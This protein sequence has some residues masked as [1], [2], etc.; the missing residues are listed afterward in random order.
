VRTTPGC[1]RWF[2]R[3]GVR[4]AFDEAYETV[5]VTQARRDRLDRAIEIMAAEPMFAPTVGRLCC[6]RGGG[7]LDR[8]RL[9]TEIG[10]WRRFTGSAI[11]SYLGLVPSESSTGGSAG[12][13][14]DHQD[15]QQARLPIVDRG[16]LAP[17]QALPAQPRAAAPASRAA[18][19]GVGAGRAGQP[20]PAPTLGA[21]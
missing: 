7:H 18:A 3:V 10:D 1:G 21:V 17:P 12:T 15:R 16:R 5:L 11:G 6:L 13:G 9:V 20:A 4:L 8:V 2:E 14:R 19:G